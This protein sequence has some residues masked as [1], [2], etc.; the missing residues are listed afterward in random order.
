M[1]V[2]LINL[3]N[4]PYHKPI[5]PI[6]ILYIGN[7]L[8]K[9]GIEFDFF[10]MNFY[11]NPY[12]SLMNKLKE[13]QPD[14]AGLSIRNIAETPRMN[15]IY[16]ETI[17]TTK[18]VQKYCKVVLGG[19]G[20]SIFPTEILKLTG[21]EYGIWGE[22]ETAIVELIQNLPNYPT[23]SLI[24]KNDE[25]FVKSDISTVL[26][27]YWE[28]YGKYY[29]VKNPIIPVQTTRGCC[30]KCSY[31][32]YP[33]LFHTE[34]LIQRPIDLVVDEMENIIENVGISTFYFVDSVFNADLNYT[35]ALLYLII[36]KNLNI[37]WYACINPTYFDDELIA[38]IKKAG[39][40]H[41]DIGI[42]SF[43]QERLSILKKPFNV[44]Q[45]KKLI[46]M[47]ETYN[48]SYGF[49]LIL[50]G[51]GETIRRNLWKTS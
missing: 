13:F 6:G 29:I 50:C 43:S 24:S 20:F 28:K 35:K 1:R 30:Y 10:D 15:E 33:L 7:A 17:R 3:I 8:Y 45:S 34:K 49:S 19:A 9:R 37:S 51:I 38:L 23:G 48:V 44:Q 42:D 39:C 47:I 21:A 36:K 46:S 40:V 41:I 32:V 26:Y 31:C 11:T 2:L 27:K 12:L 18:L 14:L 25:G 5:V 22:G 16:L 4:K